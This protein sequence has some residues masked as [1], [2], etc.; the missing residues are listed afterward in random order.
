[1]SRI[2]IDVTDAQHQKLK[3]LA[4]LQGKTIK[5][6]VLAST[7]GSQQPDSDEAMALAELEAMLDKRIRRFEME[8]PSTRTVEDIF[9][10]ARDEAKPDA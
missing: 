1:M 3:A 4:A 8:G 7:L 10:Q 5:Q 9:Q 2:S 6:F